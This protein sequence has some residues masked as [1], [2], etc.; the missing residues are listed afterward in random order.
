[1]EIDERADGTEV[2]PR[3]GD[4]LRLALVEN[5]TTG[6]RWH[7][8]RDGAPVCRLV[9]DHFEAPSPVPGAPGRRRL[10]FQVVAAGR[11]EIALEC[12]RSWQPEHPSR[13]FSVRVRA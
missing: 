10:D 8:V 13:R 4:L 3:T 6:H 12:A 9:G 7:L 1:V 2:T 11:A 5:P